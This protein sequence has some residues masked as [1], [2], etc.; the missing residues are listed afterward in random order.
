M[1]KNRLRKILVRL[2]LV[3]FS[4]YFV[5]CA[6]LYFFQEG[7]LFHPKQLK[8]DYTFNFEDDFSGEFEEMKFKTKDNISLSGILFKA[9]ESKGLVFYLHGN[10][11]TIQGVGKLAESFTSSGYDMFAMDYRGFGKST[12]DIQSEKQLIS[13]VQLTYDQLNKRYDEKNIIVVGYSMGTGFATQLTVNND[14]KQLILIA[15]Y[16]SI[17]DMMTTNYPIVPSFLLKYKLETNL[18]IQDCNVPVTL[19]HGTAD[20]VIPF[21]SSTRLQKLIKRKGK[22]IRLKGMSHGDVISKPRVLKKM[23]RILSQ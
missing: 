19:F 6:C 20:E 8:Q 1:K 14:P 11:G 2:F 10:A 12:G 23:N 22:L 3:I 18:H 7:L 21:N 9:Q 17:V 15:P 13:D 4:I 5:T 16:F